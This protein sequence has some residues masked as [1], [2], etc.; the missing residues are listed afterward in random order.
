MQMT[1]KIKKVIEW[2]FQYDS[3]KNVFFRFAPEN[4]VEVWRDDISSDW[5]VFYLDGQPTHYYFIKW[6]LFA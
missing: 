5:I 1:D 2:G 4:Y 3:E 6:E